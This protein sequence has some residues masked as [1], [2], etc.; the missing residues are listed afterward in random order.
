MR[1]RHGPQ[2]WR[3]VFPAFQPCGL[4]SD[5]EGEVR[6][7]FKKTPGAQKSPGKADRPL[8]V[9]LSR[10][11]PPGGRPELTCRAFTTATTFDVTI[12]VAVVVAV[13]VLA[14]VAVHLVRKAHINRERAVAY[15][16]VA[17]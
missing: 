15:A 1:H 12:I 10:N 5:F 9:D 6:A 16:A 7:S 14:D 8:G 2:S 11:G 13:V 17:E 3:Q 4:Y